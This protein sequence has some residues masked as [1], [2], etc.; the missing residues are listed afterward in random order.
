MA[1]I[2]KIDEGGYI[3][4]Y[5]WIYGLSTVLINSGSGHYAVAVMAPS[6][7]SLGDAKV[8]TIKIF[9]YDTGSY[10]N[11]TEVSTFE[12]EEL[13]N[14]AYYDPSLV[15]M[16]DT[17]LVM[18]YAGNGNDGY[19]KT[20]S[21][22]TGSYTITEIDSLEHDTVLGRYNSLVRMDE[23]HFVLAYAG[24]PYATIK[25]FSIDTGSYTITE[26]DSLDHATSQG[27]Y[28][29]LAKIGTGSNA[30]ALAYAGSGNDGYIKTFT[31][32]GSWNITQEDVLEH[33]TLQG[34]YNSLVSINDYEV[35][36][37][38]QGTGNDGFVKVFSFDGSWNITQDASLEHDTSN[39]AHNSLINLPDAG[40]TLLAYSGLGNDGFIKTLY[41]DRA[42]ISVEATLEHDT[43]DASLNS[44]IPIGGNY[45]AL[46]YSYQVY[47]AKTKTFQTS[48]P[49]TTITEEDDLTFLS[50]YFSVSD[51]MQI[52][53][54]HQLVSHV[55]KNKHGYLTIVSH[56]GSY[57]DITIV[58]SSVFSSASYNDTPDLFS[59]A[60]ID[61]THF[62]LAYSG[63]DTDNYIKTY[64]I[65]TGSYAITALDELEHDTVQG[66]YNS[67]IHIASGAQ[68]VLAYAGPSIDGYIKSFRYDTGSYVIQQVDE[69]EHDTTQVSYNSLVKLSDTRLALAYAGN[70]TDGYIKTFTLDGTGSI[71][72]EDVLEHDITQGSYNELVAMSPT[73]AVLAYAGNGNDG[74]IKTFTFD[75]TGSIT[76]ED[77]LEHDTSQGIYNS[78]IKVS[79]SHVIL[80]YSGNGSDGFAKIFSFDGSWNITQEASLEFDTAF[81]QFLR[82]SPIDNSHF[83]VIH[84]KSLTGSHRFGIFRTF[85]YSIYNVASIN[86]ISF[87]DISSIDTIP[88]GSVS[89][90]NS[91]NT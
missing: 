61:D 30:V 60:T 39:N 9:S 5:T 21:I 83:A 89:S 44:L 10:D 73:S 69:L 3:N 55:G 45:Y 58:S 29:S 88:I 72:Q 28:N 53:S 20:F 66:N 48:S 37:A 50:N 52:D 76:Q 31:F 38:Y 8:G 1:S 64:S 51:M 11:I 85:S 40:Y 80:S 87:G 18:A 41:W 56:D 35:M 17:H 54:T 2:T 36:L 49:Y 12:L 75:G 34:T 25:T 43:V 15:K 14:I 82:I 23:E 65:D 81:A 91:I 13:T 42:S 67:L 84:L 68:L 63:K 46:A 47:N 27:Y 74:Y 22:D 62:A 16:D 4:E 26:I 70:G 32:D 33:D 78:M 7:A 59:L 19:I 77:V 90:I 6:S 86:T 57:S 79:D 24:S 71:T